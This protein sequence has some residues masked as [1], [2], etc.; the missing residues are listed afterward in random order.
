MIKPGAYKV[1]LLKKLTDY[2]DVGVIATALIGEALGD[3]RVAHVQ[4]H[5]GYIWYR[6]TDDFEVLHELVDPDTVTKS[7]PSKPAPASASAHEQGQS[8]SLTGLDPTKITIELR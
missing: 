5:T 4:D 8:I 2:L 3:K 1:K 6:D 7:I